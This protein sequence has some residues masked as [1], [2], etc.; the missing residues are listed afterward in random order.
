VPDL[1]WIR[2]LCVSFPDVA[3][4]MPWEDTLCFKV[5]GKVFVF[6]ALAQGRFPPVTIKADPETFH[7][8]LEI[9]GISP[10]RYLARYKWVTVAN[11]NLLP[12]DDLHALVS[13]S[14]GMVAA[15]APKKKQPKQKNSKRKSLH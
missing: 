5:R 8:L 13:K 3:E 2:K 14:Y 11:S 4:D 12:A 10:A 1:D 7:E 6:T 9:E 15:K